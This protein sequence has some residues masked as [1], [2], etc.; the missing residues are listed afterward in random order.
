MTPRHLRPTPLANR[1]T[2]ALVVP[3]VAITALSVTAPAF[4]GKPDRSTTTSTAS[5]SAS[6]DPVAQNTDYTLTVRGLSASQ[7]VN[8]LVSD[9]AGTT[10]WQLMADD[11][12]VISVVGHA[13]WTGTS[14][15]T[16]QKQ[17]RHSWSVVTTC[18]FSVV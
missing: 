4:A 10:A 18:S 15:V 6:P 7:I 13:Y 11:G 5:C 1:V 2:R 3:V 14:S 17:T 12:G 9:S 8:V 16:V